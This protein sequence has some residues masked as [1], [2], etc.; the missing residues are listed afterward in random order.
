MLLYVLIFIFL[1]IINVIFLPLGYL[2]LKLL[3]NELIKERLGITTFTESG[4]MLILSG[5]VIYSDI[6]MILFFI[7]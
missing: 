7:S 1:I 2:S 4:I 6:Q 5:I 3:L